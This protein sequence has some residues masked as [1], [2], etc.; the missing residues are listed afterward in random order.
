MIRKEELQALFAPLLEGSDI[1]LVQVQVVP[2]HKQHQL[3]IFVDRPGGIDIGACARLSREI[4]RLLEERLD[5]RGGYRLEVS[6]PGMNRPIWT[7]EHYRRF[8]GDRL[9]FDLVEPR[10]GRT[11]YQGTIAAVDGE[12]VT[13]EAE[14]GETFTLALTEIASA[15]LDL[16]PWKGRRP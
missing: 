16:D 12:R 15:T 7:L 11:R 3:R 14:T 9:Q 1:E 4:A 13:L 10:D 8:Q 6:S 5:L 2:G